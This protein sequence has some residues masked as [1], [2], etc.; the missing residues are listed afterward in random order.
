MINTQIRDDALFNHIYGGFTGRVMGSTMGAIA[1][2]HTYEDIK[3]THGTIDRYAGFIF[4]ADGHIP[5]IPNDDEMFEMILLVALEENGMDVTTMDIA[6]KWLELIDPRFTFT[7]ER[8]AIE[9]FQRGELM[10]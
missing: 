8:V 7:A 3:S 9:R 1:E 5:G 6:R 10:F 2:N 4:D